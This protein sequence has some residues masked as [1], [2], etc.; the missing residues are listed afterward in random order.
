M[1]TIRTYSFVFH[2]YCETHCMLSAW[3]R[4]TENYSGQHQCVTSASAVEPTIT[5]RFS[6]IGVTFLR[7][8]RNFFFSSSPVIIVNKF[9]LYH[10]IRIYTSMNLV[11]TITC[12]SHSCSG[13]APSLEV[14]CY[15][16]S[17][18][19]NSFTAHIYRELYST[20]W[21]WSISSYIQKSPPSFITS[22]GNNFDIYL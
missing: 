9:I 10:G 1:H 14:T 13:R 21:S 15:M 11:N 20:H 17:I 6:I 16:D 2:I 18:R 5:I 19:R 4:S 8:S 3:S 12:I 7:N 22:T